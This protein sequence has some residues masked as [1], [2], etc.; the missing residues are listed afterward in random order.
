MGRM[1]VCEFLKFNLRLNLP[2]TADKLST[3]QPYPFP[4]SQVLHPHAPN[5][6]HKLG[7][8]SCAGRICK[9]L[10]FYSCVFSSTEATIGLTRCYTK[11]FFRTQNLLFLA[12]M[13]PRS[14]VGCFISITCNEICL[15][16]FWIF[17]FL[18]LAS[19]RHVTPDSCC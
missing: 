5:C 15:L 19:S 17:F 16:T 1:C 4:I 12:H 7:A 9:G 11:F 3:S 6:N 14:Q 2:S 13:P 8:R 18:L 10:F